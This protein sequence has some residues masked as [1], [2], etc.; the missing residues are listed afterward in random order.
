MSPSG[1]WIRDSSEDSRR[2]PRFP[3]KSAVW[4][5]F[6]FWPPRRAASCRAC[7]R[8]SAGRTD[9]R[10]NTGALCLESSRLA[11]SRKCVRSAPLFAPSG[12]HSATPTATATRWNATLAVVTFSSVRR[13]V[14]VAILVGRAFPILPAPVEQGHEQRFVR[15]ER[16]GDRAR[17]VDLNAADRELDHARVRAVDP[18]PLYRN[19]TPRA[20][21]AAAT[22]RA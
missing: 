4:R 19:R 11:R 17:V 8:K 12:K 22:A 2:P 15:V 18:P 20:S 13:V 16:R 21:F 5:G 14:L 3:R 9:Q 6:F 7:P 10:E 1:C